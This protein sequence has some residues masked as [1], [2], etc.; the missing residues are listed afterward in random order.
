MLYIPVHFYSEQAS[1]RTK[2]T[3]RYGT[4]GRLYQRK[5]PDIMNSTYYEPKFKRERF[6]NYSN[7]L[8]R[9]QVHLDFITTRGWI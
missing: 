5:V 1:K 4:F 2:R 9:S 7:V 6:R 8:F 3:K